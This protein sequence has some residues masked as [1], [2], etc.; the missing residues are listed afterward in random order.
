VHIT[1]RSHFK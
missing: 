1:R